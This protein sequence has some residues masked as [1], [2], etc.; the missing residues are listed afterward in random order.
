M[1]LMSHANLDKRLSEKF[2]RKLTFEFK[3]D[4]RILKNF[5]PST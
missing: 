1:T 4:M 3:I 2:E 5:D